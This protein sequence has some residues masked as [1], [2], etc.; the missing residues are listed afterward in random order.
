M[1]SMPV[2]MMR[3]IVPIEGRVIRSDRF[4]TLSSY[5]SERYCLGPGGPAPFYKKCQEE[6]WSGV[7]SQKNFLMGMPL[8]NTIAFARTPM[9]GLQ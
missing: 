2:L 4:V 5:V 3:T 7:S 9:L 6:L 1:V 8:P